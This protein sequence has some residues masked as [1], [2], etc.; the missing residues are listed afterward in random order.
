MFAHDVRDVD[1]MYAKYQQKYDESLSEMRAGA[2]LTA[3][4]QRRFRLDVPEP[5][6]FL[7]NHVNQ[8]M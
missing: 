4:T 3:H 6:G 7:Q 5:S 2:G 8:Q 1:A